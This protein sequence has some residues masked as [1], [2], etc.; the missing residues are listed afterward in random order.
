MKS[1][2]SLRSA[3]LASTALLSVAA[4]ALPQQAAAVVTPETVPPG[5]AVDTTNTRPYMVGLM[6]RNEA[7]NSGGTCT[8]LLINPRTVLFA[9]HCVD[10]LAPGAY[11]GNSPGNRAQVG[12]TT[13]PTFGLTNMREF[14]F[15]QDFNVS[16]G[17]ARVVNGSSVMVWY[18]PRS[19]NGSARSAS[20]N[21]FL[22]ADVA[23]A[24]FDTATELLGRDGANGIG[25]L[26]S[27][28]NGQ[29]PVTIGGYGQAGN[30]LTGSRLSGTE[31]TFFRR[32]GKNMLGFLGDERSISL[33]VYGTAGGNFF[34]PPGFTYQ[35]LYWVD[36]D[37]PQRATR[38]FS[39]SATRSSTLNTFDFDIFPGAAV[40]GEA[41]TASGDSG[42]PLI[43]SAYGREVS[44]GVLSQGTSFFFDV[45]GNT[46]DNFVFQSTFS[47]Y[48][49]IAGYNP[50]FLFW[51]QIVVNNPYK[52]VTTKAGDGEWTD[53]TRW[54]QE[55][56]PLYYVLSGSTLVN[57]LPTTPALGVSGATPNI[58]TI[59]PNP[60]PVATCAFTGTC[61]P[62]A[63]KSEP[64][65]LGLGDS[66]D[67]AMPD[68][69][70]LI[71][72]VSVNNL[73]QPGTVELG[74]VQVTTL[75][76]E[77]A[78]KTAVSAVTLS[79]DANNQAQSTALWSSGTLIGVNTGTLTG[80]GTTNF[81][82]NNTAGTAGLQNSTR[83]FEVN[84]RSAGTT[85]LT[86]TTVTIDRLNVRGAASGLTIRSGA[87]LNTVI[88][89]FG[90][91]GVL[92]V[93]GVFNPRAY[94][95]SGGAIYGSGQIIA[96]GGVAIQNG[97]VSAGAAN[98]G[99]GTLS[100]TG[101]VVLGGSSLMGVDVSSATSADLLAVT[102]T[103]TLGGSL[104]VAARNGYVPTYG[105]RWTVAT[106]TAPLTGSFATVSSNFPGVLRPA[107]LVS[108]SNLVVEVTALPYATL[109]SKTNPLSNLLDANRASYSTLKPV[110]DALD[111]LGAG[112][113]DA[114][115]SA[116]QPTAGFDALAL[117][118]LQ[119][120][121]IQGTD[122]GLGG[123]SGSSLTLA[124]FRDHNQA[125]GLNAQAD[126]PVRNEI[127][128][129][130]STFAAYR[131]LNG[132][133]ASLNATGRSEAES[134]ILSV[135]ADYA[136]T[137]GLRLGAAAHFADGEATGLGT[138]A[139]SD[140]QQFTLFA[141]YQNQGFFASAYGG[142]GRQKLK[143]Q[144][145]LAL[146]GQVLTAGY[147]A[148]VTTA[149]AVLG[150]DI[151]F[152]RQGVVLFGSTDAL[153]LE[154]DGYSETG[155]GFALKVG[156]QSF[157]SVKTRLGLSYYARF[158]AFGGTLKPGLTL[159]AVQDSEAKSTNS[160]KVA[161]AIA[162]TLLTDVT[163]PGMDKEWGE[164]DLHVDYDSG[165][166]WGVSVG[167]RGD[168]HREDISANTAYVVLKKTF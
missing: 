125:L 1:L 78:S 139:N 70:T 81:V 146:N 160:A 96:P 44:L 50:L 72:T 126:E 16:K 88:S 143:T 39:A 135:G 94:T 151:A 162:P 110:Y 69:Q 65:D 127:G 43:T 168:V 80:P 40:A 5:A 124:G 7:G 84:L 74:A 45:A 29:V 102:G 58:G 118:R 13:D 51:D 14:L 64:V 31:D 15:G 3:C 137:S 27:P 20:D 123:A 131:N 113:L 89:S 23:I 133:M 12:Y 22:S 56:D 32:L 55:I 132:D 111:P 63:G 33:G 48:G 147:D 167:Y 79:P 109:L 49:G 100:V 19:R 121:A 119:A 4:L 93:D 61:V 82:P 73:A 21:S 17:D 108:G 98:G 164:I 60:S 92:T 155:G 134:R 149:G 138:K 153:K 136:V 99:V 165:K 130:L 157:E 103:L 112:A 54:T 59:T 9:A 67:R 85:F 76:M 142:P 140:M 141:R 120:G 24:G 47:N 10:G 95:L 156:E 150:Y 66:A 38:A 57:G 37:D 104:S 26:F 148:D 77:S 122:F 52:Y 106:A 117:G 34:D 86:G 107:A 18:D 53:A 35:D 8:G 161:F 115:F 159:A 158:N 128:G 145:N 28:V 163:T 144:R 46:N 68:T 36:F 97:I 83:W 11:D 105:T 101:N 75:S 129:G 6:I 25:L 42:S 71:S 116:S 154:T 87:R 91:D 90:D 166:A 152:D 62:G 2:K 114:A 30:A 41:L